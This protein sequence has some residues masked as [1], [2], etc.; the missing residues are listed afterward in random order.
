MKISNKL[1]IKFHN[2]RGYDSHLNIK[3]LNLI[4]I[5]LTNDYK[6]F[7]KK[8]KTS[9]YQYYFTFSFFQTVATNYFFQVN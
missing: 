1:P 8:F 5:F 3:E 6:N 2:L 7:F 4:V 9:K